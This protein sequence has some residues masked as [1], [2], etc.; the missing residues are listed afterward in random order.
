MTDWVDDDLLPSSDLAEIGRLINEVPSQK[1]NREAVRQ[2]NHES[3]LFIS[4]ATEIFN[5]L[6]MINNWDYY[7]LGEGI[8]E[9]CE[10]LTR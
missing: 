10:I 4:P 3:L 7:L 2:G 5:C 8:S 1:S 9:L 6:T